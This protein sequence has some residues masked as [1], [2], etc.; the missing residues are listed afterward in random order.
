[1]SATAIPK[2]QDASLPR[3]NVN[4][5][6]HQQTSAE[7]DLPPLPDLSRELLE[8]LRQQRKNLFSAQEKEDAFSTAAE[9]VQTHSTEIVNRWNTEIDTYLVFAGLF[10]AILT[11][12]NVQS[13]QLLQGPSP[14]DPSTALLQQISEQLRS[15]SIYPPFINATH[16]LSATPSLSSGLVAA[17]RPRVPLWAIW[18]NI[19][20]FSGLILSLAAAVMGITVKQWLNEYTSG[21]F[22][23]SRDTARLRQYRFTNL[24][25]W[26][27]GT[28]V[29]IIPLLLQ[30]SLALFLAGLLILLWTLHPAVAS[31][32]SVLV[33]FIA[34][35]I[36]GTTVLPVFKSGCAYLSPL[37]L[38]LYTS[39]QHFESYMH[40]IVLHARIVL[41]AAATRPGR[42]QSEMAAA[43]RPWIAASPRTGPIGLHARERATLNG[44]PEDTLDLD[45]MLTACNVTL[46][47]AYIASAA[48][49]LTDRDPPTVVD[50]VCRLHESMVAQFGSADAH[51]LLRARDTHDLL[52]WNFLF[53]VLASD[54]S[55]VGASLS[56]HA[57]KQLRSMYHWID[58][59]LKSAT[60]LIHPNTTD[61]PAKA[62]LKKW[63]LG[64]S[65]LVVDTHDKQMAESERVQEGETRLLPRS[66]V[67]SED[68]ARHVWS[69]IDESMDYSL[70]TDIS[71][72]LLGE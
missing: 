16:A 40:T 35:F 30:I 17:P 70:V 56:S 63:L 32:A 50:F 47:P 68:L 22:G 49:Y 51:A 58:D 4:R 5:D 38:A 10:S 33:T 29:M 21:L 31:I 46:D 42:I 24:L 1:M 7:D 34:A 27:V 12:F 25:E 71:V 64:L 18:L 52:S 61:N 11:A 23:N 44:I 43:R 2:A 26:K 66:D 65:L 13:Y 14:P 6:D 36:L 41:V 15:F 59:Q 57:T 62:A 8:D 55:S 20:W 54:S 45:I 69:R 60:L 3:I 37:A 19:T 39:W 53:S 28:V 67:V 48:R 72:L 9:V